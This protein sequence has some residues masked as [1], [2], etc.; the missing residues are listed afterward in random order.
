MKRNEILALIHKTL[1]LVAP[2]AKYNLGNYD[3][4]RNNNGWV[5]E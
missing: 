4:F 5:N 3:I 2:N 1:K